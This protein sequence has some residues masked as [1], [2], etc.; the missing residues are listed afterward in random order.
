MVDLALER[1]AAVQAQS[2]VLGISSDLRAER[3]GVSRGVR[4]LLAEGWTGVAANQYAAGW[5]DWCRGSEEMMRALTT[6]GELMGAVRDAI[7]ETDT[8]AATSSTVL[9]SRLG[10]LP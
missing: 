4:A 9:V 1:A 10:P 5:D 7:V 8:H 2:D 3:D 6:I